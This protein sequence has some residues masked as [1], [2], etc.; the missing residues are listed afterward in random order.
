MLSGGFKYLTKPLFY[1][2][3]RWRKWK[4]KTWEVSGSQRKCSRYCAFVAVSFRVRFCVARLLLFSL[5]VLHIC[6]CFLSCSFL[7]CAFV[8]VF[9]RV[10][11]YIASEKARR[12]QG[13]M[14]S[15]LFTPVPS[16][17]TGAPSA[18]TVRKIL[19]VWA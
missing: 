8:A 16:F 6:H 4:E 13:H 17:P 5:V 10:H 14:I 7:C 19:C 15:R 11:F 1:F 2:L 9:P 3:N 12:H 18:H